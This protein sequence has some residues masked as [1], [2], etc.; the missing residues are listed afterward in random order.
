MITIQRTLQIAFAVMASLGTML[1]GM[2]SDNVVLPIVAVFVAVTSVY[3]T[4]IVGWIRLNRTFASFAALLA[5]AIALTDFFQLQGERQLLAIAYLLIYL[6]IVVMYQQKDTR[7]YWQLFMLS[8]LQVVVAAALNFSAIF[9]LLLALYLVIA[10]FVLSLFFLYRDAGE[11]R[12]VNSF[13]ASTNGSGQRDSG[14]RGVRT[15][16]PLAQSWHEDLL[17]RRLVWRSIAESIVTVG[18]TLVFFLLLPRSGDLAMAR[19]VTGQRMVGF[20]D[21]VRL[22]DLG[23]ISDDYSSVMRVWFLD[24]DDQPFQLL[25]PP[26]FRGTVVNHYENSTW[27]LRF[28]PRSEGQVLSLKPLDA[29]SGRAVRQTI[30]LEPQHEDTVCAVYPVYELSN[31]TPLL[32]DS[33]KQQLLRQRTRLS[34]IEM[35][36]A[37]T[38]FER[39]VQLDITPVDLVVERYRSQ[40]SELTQLPRVLSDG[41]DPLKKLKEAAAE[42]LADTDLAADDRIGRARALEQYLRDSGEFTYSLRTGRSDP[43]LDPVEDFIANN[44]SGHCEYFSSALTL[45]LRSQNIPAR[46]VIGFNGGKWN[47]LGSYYQVRQLN[48]HSW[49][50][51]YLN[52]IP[53]NH[54]F[55]DSIGLPKPGWLRL[56][57]TPTIAI[58]ERDSNQLTLAERAR[59][60]MNY[61]EYLWSDYIVDL[62]ARRQREGI[63]EPLSYTVDH[64]KALMSRDFWARGLPAAVRKAA[65]DGTLP[66]LGAWLA[67]LLI[68][69]LTLAVLLFRRLLRIL[70]WPG[71]PWH[72]RRSKRSQ[73]PATASVGFY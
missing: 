5:V 57:P 56:D 70:P 40:E 48:A 62:N 28:D 68:C 58:E 18:L 65:E 19:R 25:R 21:T 49:V 11:L 67:A 16:K 27:T 13:G 55:A 17:N 60:W 31:N 20:T 32:F 29:S 66:Y 42:V 53:E 51:V 46:M 59:E 44:P 9:G 63:Y 73:R 39:N 38:G 43:D 2:G 64:V 7:I 10:L 22:G 23:N 14:R 45:M 54:P 37:T 50:E 36:V 12:A 34:K 72:W 71:N 30:H 4:D 69:A 52:D 41:V 3:F 26:M 24:S 61:G 33:R 47:S 35:T 15:T 1:L 8:L 6:Q